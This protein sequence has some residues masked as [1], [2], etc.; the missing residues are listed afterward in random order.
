MTP[1]FYEPSGTQVI[2]DRIALTLLAN[3]CIDPLVGRAKMSVNRAFWKID[4]RNKF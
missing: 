3:E 4:V 2:S 1:F